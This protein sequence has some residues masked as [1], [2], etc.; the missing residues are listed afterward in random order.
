MPDSG[1]G[2]PIGCRAGGAGAGPNRNGARHCCQA[3][4]RR[5][6]DLPV[7]VTLIHEPEGPKT[8]PRSWRTSSGVAFHL[9]GPKTRFVVRFSSRESLAPQFPSAWPKGFRDLDVPR[10]FLGWVPFRGLSPWGGNH[11]PQKRAPA[12]PAPLAD[13]S[14]THFAAS[15]PRRTVQLRTS[16][17][18]L[19]AEIGPSVACRTFLPLPALRGGGDFRPD[20]N[21]NVHND[22][23]SR[24][25]EN[26][27]R[28]LWITGIL[29]ITRDSRAGISPIVTS[30][31]PNSGWASPI[32]PK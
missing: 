23:E 15:S 12:L 16:F 2:L 5:A 25:A 21:W 6:K 1:K 8:R 7:F 4:L 9:G 10:P 31:G 24:Q 11:L 19:P 26:A 29:R 27:A 18:R 17:H 30:R 13:W 22:S 14:G 3:P 32:K 20:H 28:S